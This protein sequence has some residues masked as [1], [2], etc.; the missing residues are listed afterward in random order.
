[1]NRYAV[2][3]A[4]LLAGM[5][6][7]TIA[8][9]A[10]PVELRILAINDF[11][12]YLRPSPG[13]ITIQDPAD[14]AKKTVIPAGGA[15][16][17]ATLVKQLRAGH[18]NS[19]FV[20]A[21][22]LIGASPFL[23]AMFHDEPTIESLSLMGLD[24]AAV[25]NHEFDEGKTE[26]L[27]MQHGG[28]HPT[29]NCR[30]PHPFLGARFKYLAASTVDSATG[31][32]LFPP[33]EIRTF[34]GIPVGFI[35]LTLKA[36]PNMVSPP[37]VAGLEF[38]DE[39]ETVNT[40]VAELKTLGVKAIVVLIHEG[41]WPTGGIN[42]CP[43]ISGPI[44]DI[45][46]KFDKAVDVVISGHT[47]RAYSCQIDGRLVTSGDKYGT[48]V[49]AIDLRLDPH[50]RDVISAKADNVIVR[51]KTLAKDPQQTALIDSYD[52]LAGP[53]AA[54]PAGSVS[55]T[56]VRLPNEAGES[57]LGDIIADA[58]LAATAAEADGGAVIAFTNPGG[59]RADITKRADGTVS[60]GD[61]FA[62]QPFRNQLVTLTLT[63]AQIK[64]ALEQQWSDP[65]R[66]R[67]LQVS[68]HFSY[69]WDNAG[70]PG[71]RVPADKITLNGAPLD[72][73]GHY[74][75]TVNAFLAAGGD[76]FTTFKDGSEPRIGV[77]D[78]D[79]LFNF[80][81]AGSPVSPP[82]STRILRLN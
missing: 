71:A 50:S 54:Q 47:H 39:A 59:V 76:G 44:V 64:A 14:P 22:D 28:C 31:K 27:R 16:Y 51:T 37:G 52:Q 6:S 4:M 80:L 66:P 20:A 10:K 72:P 15:E 35:G 32:T 81:K 36:T 75:V 5:T 29:D 56:L 19:I 46:K 26:L 13:G 65:Q 8:E 17:M 1:M 25:G 40:Q 63:G 48:L 53:I 62:A 61:V 3:A 69:A 45:V 68:G 74:R 38:R 23:S 49:T 57:P 79:A 21:G 70:Q 9:T 55:A 82:P 58:Q 77:Y 30:G 18:A 11:H 78:V 67:M 73:T 2:I 24:L 42:E 41:G 43:G 34:N 7:P 12:G 33:Y 60:Y